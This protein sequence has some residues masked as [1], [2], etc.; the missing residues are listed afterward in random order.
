M[1]LIFYSMIRPPGNIPEPAATVV[2]WL[3]RAVLAVSVV[4]M[5]ASPVVLRRSAASASGTTLSAWAALIAL[6]ASAAFQA[7]CEFVLFKPIE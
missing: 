1:A 4:S 3:W 2:R 7:L 6:C 5:L